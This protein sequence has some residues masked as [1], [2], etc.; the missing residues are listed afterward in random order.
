MRPSRSAIAPAGRAAGGRGA[1]ARAAWEA[2]LADSPVR[3][4]FER[5]LT[6]Q[7]RDDV[8]GA[9]ETALSAL[10]ANPA[11]IPVRQGSLNATA[12]LSAV[13]P[14][15]V[16]GSADLTSSVLSKPKGMEPLTPQNFAGRHISFGIR[17]HGMAAA[18]NGIALHGGFTPYAGTYLTFSDYARPA[19]RLA[20]LMGIRD[21]FLMTHDS[22]GVGEDGPTHQP[23]EHVASLRTI[24]GLRVYRPADAV[25]ALECWYDAVTGDGPSVMVAARQKVPQV[26]LT[27][28]DEMLSRR[29]AYVLAGGARRDLTLLASGSEV[30]LALDVRRLLAAHGIEAAVISM[31]CWERFAEQDGRYRAEV[32][33]SAPRFAIEA[34]SPF[35]WE[36]FTGRS[37]HIFGVPTFGFSAPGPTVYEHFGLTPEAISSEILRLSEAAKLETAN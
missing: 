11:A 10:V 20:A 22:I 2:R 1:D 9:V 37:D 14:E 30:S 13:M 34:A 26:R 25:E 36:R 27:A 6:G 8:R 32:L 35:G 24:P 15:L 5:R 12:V 3:S 18:L 21:I 31:P 19:I 33:G 17:E 16:G 28:T 29:G 23:I 7:L 4:E